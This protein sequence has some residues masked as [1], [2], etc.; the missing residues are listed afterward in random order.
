MGRQ[1]HTYNVPWDR[2]FELFDNHKQLTCCVLSTSHESSPKRFTTFSIAA[3]SGPMTS[4]DVDTAGETSPFV[5]GE[6]SSLV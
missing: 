2:F 5:D 6:P 1:V 4:S 3:I